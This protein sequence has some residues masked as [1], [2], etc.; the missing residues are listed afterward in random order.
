MNHSDED[1]PCPNDN[2]SLDIFGLG[3]ICEDCWHEDAGIRAEMRAAGYLRRRSDAE[4][5]AAGITAVCYRDP[6]TGERYE[7]RVGERGVFT[8]Q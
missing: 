1:F 6:L 8:C 7:I 2:R 3:C 4:L 5:L